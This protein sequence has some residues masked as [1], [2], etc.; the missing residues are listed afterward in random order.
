MAVFVH[1]FRVVQNTTAGKFIR[2][3]AQCRDFPVAEAAYTRAV[4]LYPGDVI[5]LQNGGKL[6]KRSDAP[7]RGTNR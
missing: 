2:E 1:P 6:L 3:L 5:T 7:Q 4:A